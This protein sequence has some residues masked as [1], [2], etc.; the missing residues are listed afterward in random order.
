[1]N[2]NFNNYRRI[3]V[4]LGWSCNNNCIFCAETL[5]RKNA[6]KKGFL[7]IKQDQIIKQ[8]LIWS[9]KGADHVTFLGGE[10][11]INKNIFKY[12]NY[13]KKLGYRT[14][15]MATNARMCSNEEFTK[16]LIENGLNE[17]SVSLHGY[18]SQSH[19]AATR[20][21]D[22]FNQ[23]YQGLINLTKYCEKV[24]VNIII[25]NYNYQNLDKIM[26]LILNLN[27]IRILI[28]YPIFVGNAIKYNEMIPSYSLVYKNIHKAINIIKNKFKITVMNVPFC[29][30]QGYEEYSDYLGYEKRK[31]LTPLGEA[32]PINEYENT[33]LK[34]KACNN[35]KYDIV[36]P[37][38]YKH[39]ITYKG[40]SEFKSIE[41]K[42]IEKIVQI[43]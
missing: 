14:I 43:Y 8:L 29:F 3:E 18:N 34:L 22:S 25:N 11:T 21:K 42:K 26:E 15:F 23:T 39:Y 1:M 17:I 38:I 6:I 24:M 35:C 19:E 16:K 10:P 20:A 5:N 4:M 36:C 13:A 7:I 32:S 40:K 27:L 33:H 37:G 30:L 2:Y 28:T 41:G 9:K 12:C 31:I